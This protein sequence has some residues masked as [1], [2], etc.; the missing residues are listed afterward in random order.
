[1]NL[2]RREMV[3]CGVAAIAS[4]PS[5]ASVVKGICGGKG[6]FSGS[7]GEDEEAMYKEM[8]LSLT[9]GISTFGDELV[10]DVSYRIR[11]WFASN[12]T[13]FTKLTFSVA[14]DIQGHA[15]RGNSTIREISIPAASMTGAYAFFNDSSL[16]SI[17]APICKDMGARSLEGCSSLV[18]VYVNDVNF[19]ETRNFPWGCNNPNTVF[20]FADGNVVWSDAEGKWVKVA[21]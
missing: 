16:V 13:A 5:C 14:T 10:D 7:N 8:Y 1:M 11:P 20:H 19:N 21:S 4:C 12:L 3:V 6:L 2:T 15:F 17:E 9:T 18:A